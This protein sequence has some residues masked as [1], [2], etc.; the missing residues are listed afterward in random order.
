M[1]HKRRRQ[2]KSHLD[3]DEDE[4]E[5]DDDDE[6]EDE[7]LDGP[8]LYWQVDAMREDAF[9]RDE[10]EAASSLGA[11]GKSHEQLENS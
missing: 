2:K 11:S 10:M 6:E 9:E 5:D 4:D 1:K 3:D 7:A 8:M